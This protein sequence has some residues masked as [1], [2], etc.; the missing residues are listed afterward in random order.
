MNYIQFSLDLGYLLRKADDYAGL[1][2]S[3]LIVLGS[4]GIDLGTSGS[5]AGLGSLASVGMVPGG[6][7]GELCQCPDIYFGSPGGF[8]RTYFG[9]FGVPRV[10]ASLCWNFRFPLWHPF[11][12]FNASET[13]S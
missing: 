10:T 4:L 13:H 8:Q 3:Y 6:R 2:G 5:S 1:L 11:F 7:L 12:H 9:S